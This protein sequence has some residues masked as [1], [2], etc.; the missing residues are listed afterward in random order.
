[1]K[2]PHA[3]FALLV[4]L[5]L[6][7][8]GWTQWQRRERA[9]LERELAALKAAPAAEPA[10]TSPAAQPVSLTPA[11]Q[12]ELLALRGRVAGLLRQRLELAAQGGGAARP[13]GAAA[14]GAPSLHERLGLP[15]DY[16][17][18]SQFEF[19]G[20]QTPA[21]ALESL[22]AATRAK[23]TNLVLAALTG[24]MARQVAL[25]LQ[26]HGAEVL[27]RDLGVPPGFRIL[28]EDQESAGS[29]RMQVELLPGEQP[30]PVLAVQGPD[31]T[32][33]LDLG[34]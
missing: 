22:F 33:K 2:T 24:D 15:P 26:A 13:K 20:F 23:D 11:E 31:G 29:V 16:R 18:A 3:W 25:Q 10:P 5:A 30:M 34:R 19:R 17:L 9:A 8:L 6:A 32:W 1:M 21:A 4:A 28:T 12:E 7:G 14:A 27:E